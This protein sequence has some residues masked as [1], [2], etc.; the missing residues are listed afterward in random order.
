MNSLNIIK[1]NAN[2]IYLRDLRDFG[3]AIA[4]TVFVEKGDKCNIVQVMA[5]KGWEKGFIKPMVGQTARE[6][7]KFDTS[8]EMLKKAQDHIDSMTKTEGIMIQPFLNYVESI[9]EFSAVFFG[10]KLSHII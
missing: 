5:E 9:G 1:W 3:V 10:N 8:R 4:P 6:T 7:L 2:K